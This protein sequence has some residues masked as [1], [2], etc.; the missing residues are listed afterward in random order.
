MILSF[1]LLLRWMS[2][3]AVVELGTGAGELVA[4]SLNPDMSAIIDEAT[5]HSVNIIHTHPY[6]GIR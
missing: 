5:S 2:G 4:Q 3:W 6:K 1:S